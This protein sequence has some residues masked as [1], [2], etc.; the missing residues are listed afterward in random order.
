MNAQPAEL[1]NFA[2]ITEIELRVFTTD[3]SAAAG[4]FALP[5]GSLQ[6]LKLEAAQNGFVMKDDPLRG[7]VKWQVKRFT[8]Q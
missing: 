3:S 7:K 1:V 5:K 8:T 6:T 2:D 4:L